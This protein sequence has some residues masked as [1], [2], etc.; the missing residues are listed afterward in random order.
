MRYD[1]QDGPS[2][3]GQASISTSFSAVGDG[4]QVVYSG[5]ILRLVNEFSAYAESVFAGGV[6]SGQ[7]CFEEIDESD[8]DSL[9]LFT[10]S[11]YGSENI[12]FA[13]R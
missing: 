5:C 6:V 1:G 4:T 11:G 10:D 12:F 2:Y 8:I 3:P 7:D 13:T 9:L